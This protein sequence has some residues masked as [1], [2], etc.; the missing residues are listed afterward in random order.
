MSDKSGFGAIIEFDELQ[1]K[2]QTLSDGRHQWIAK[3]VR[4]KPVEKGWTEFYAEVWFSNPGLKDMPNELCFRI[5]AFNVQFT[6]G[7]HCLVCVHPSLI[8]PVQEGLYFEGDRL[9]CDPLEDFENFWRPLRRV[10][11]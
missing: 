6:D 9:L 8:V 7:G 5:P 11:S 4:D 2:L 3:L 1:A 10:L